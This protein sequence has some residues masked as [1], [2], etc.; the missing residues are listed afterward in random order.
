MPNKG[1]AHVKCLV[2]QDRWELWLCSGQQ[3][4]RGAQISPLDLHVRVLPQATN[5]S[6]TS[7]TQ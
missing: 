6:C 7:V 5:P 4:G 3:E 2:L 1:Q